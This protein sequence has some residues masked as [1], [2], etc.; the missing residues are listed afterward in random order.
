MSRPVEKVLKM[1]GL[2]WEGIV[3]RHLHLFCLPFP[4]HNTCRTFNSV[5]N[6]LSGGRTATGD[7]VSRH[8]HQLLRNC[9][10]CLWQSGHLLPQNPV[11]E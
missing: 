5:D 7:A 6:V 3:S 1:H 8:L 2:S 9:P 10:S 11:Q 4:N